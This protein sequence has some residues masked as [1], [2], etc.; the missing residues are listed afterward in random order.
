MRATDSSLFFPKLT[1]RDVF[2]MKA[3]GEFYAY[4]R[5]R[6]EAAED[7]QHRCVYCDAEA[8]EVGGPEAMQLDHFRPESF[9][10]FAHLINDPRNIHYA[11]GRCNIWKSDWWPNDEHR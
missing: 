3:N 11:C 7:C 6:E 10:E 5:Y 8:D 4:T 2:P 1:R 9:P